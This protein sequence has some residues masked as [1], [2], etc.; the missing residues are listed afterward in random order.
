MDP[1]SNVDRLVRLLR[2]RLQE[3]A[4]AQRTG[5][6]LVQQPE[7]GPRDVPALQALAASGDVGERPL[8]RALIEHILADRLDN[9]LL[10]DARFQ[11]IVERVTEALEEDQETAAL[12]ARVVRDLRSAAR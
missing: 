10:N 3:R 12:L 1:V 11:Q 8:R 5:A 9:R 4:R 7:T 6:P 2:A